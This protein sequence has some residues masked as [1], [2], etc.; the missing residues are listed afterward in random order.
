M[1]RSF[2]RCVECLPHTCLLRRDA[3]LLA[4]PPSQAYRKLA[5]KYHPDKQTG[6]EAA[7]LFQRAKDAQ[8]LLA[9]EAARAALDALLR[10]AVPPG[11][12]HDP[13]PC[14]C[15]PSER[16]EHPDVSLAD[17]SVAPLGNLALLMALAVHSTTDSASSAITSTFAFPL[18]EIPAHPFRRGTCARDASC[19]YTAIGPTAPLRHHRSYGAALQLLCETGHSEVF[20]RAE[21]SQSCS[22]CPLCSC[23]IFTSYEAAGP[24]SQNVV[25]V[26]GPLAVAAPCAAPTISVLYKCIF[27]I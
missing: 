26:E 8:D 11:P 15:G 16:R 20:A 13:G 7:R 5:L 4:P 24:L 1:Q 25:S 21:A 3:P 17:A 6:E 10:C 2:S 18:L 12:E 9:D 27:F 19:R 22:C 23:F 14:A